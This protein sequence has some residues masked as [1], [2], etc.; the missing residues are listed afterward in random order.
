MIQFNSVLVYTLLGKYQ[1]MLCWL[2]FW[3]LSVFRTYR[4]NFILVCVWY[5]TRWPLSTNIL[6]TS[7]RCM[8]PF[9]QKQDID[10]SVCLSL[11]KQYLCWFLHD[12][13]LY[14]IH[15]S[16]GITHWMTLEFYS[17]V[18][19]EVSFMFHKDIT[20]LGLLFEV[21]TFLR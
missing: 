19:L 6:H 9:G 18:N 3:L 5:V 4:D 13:W 16:A 21:Q 2:I 10:A 7:I 8:Q 14:L 20:T 17:N 15:V 12:V 11:L 1:K